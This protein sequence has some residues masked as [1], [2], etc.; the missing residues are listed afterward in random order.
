MRKIV[1]ISCIIVLGCVL[2]C[3]KNYDKYPAIPSGSSQNIANAIIEIPSGTSE[4]WEMSKTDK[5]LRLEY[6]N[7]EPRIINYLPYPFNYGMIP[8]TLL[9][10]ENG[11]DGD[12]LDIIVLGDKIKRGKVVEVK[13]LGILSMIDR[14]EQDDKII[15]VSKESKLY[16]FDD[17]SQ[18]L[19]EMKGV[20]IIIKTWFANYKGK[21][22]IFVREIKDSEEA[23]RIIKLSIL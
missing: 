1:D 22:K 15:A 10:E 19:K 21:N 14:G 2:S 12:P 16:K 5:K 20:D 11:G 4:K 18:L 3:S 13:V 17:I 8:N 6:V 9:S 7:N 23:M